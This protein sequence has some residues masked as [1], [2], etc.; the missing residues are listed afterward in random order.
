MRMLSFIELFNTPKELKI[1]KLC[2]KILILANNSKVL[3]NFLM[4]SQTISHKKKIIVIIKKQENII[5]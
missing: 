1:N 2:K 3:F 5:I 4:Y